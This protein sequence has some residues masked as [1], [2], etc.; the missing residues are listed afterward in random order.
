[1]SKWW[2]VKMDG[3]KKVDTVD[4]EVGS[5]SSDDSQIQKIESVVPDE[6]VET[7]IVN[8]MRVEEEQVIERN[9]KF[10]SDFIEELSIANYEIMS[11]SAKTNILKM[12]NVI[13]RW[14]MSRRTS[15]ESKQTEPKKISDQKSSRVQDL[16]TGESLQTNK[17]QQK[18]DKLKRLCESTD[19]ENNSSSDNEEEFHRLI[20]EG[21][22]HNE[23]KS[24]KDNKDIPKVKRFT[25]RNS[26]TNEN[27]VLE[28]LLSKI[29]S[30]KTPVLAKYDEKGSMSLQ[31]YLESF[32]EYCEDNLKGGKPNLG[33][34]E[35]L[36]EGDTLKAFKSVKDAVDSYET[37]KGKL[38]NWYDDMKE[39]RKERY[40]IEFNGIKPKLS[41]TLSQYSSRTEKI[42]KLAYPKQNIENSSSLKNKFITTLLPKPV[43][44]TFT[45]LVL[46]AGMNGKKVT[47]S[48]I[49]KCARLKDIELEKK[50]RETH[51]EDDHDDEDDKPIEINIQHNKQLKEVNPD[52]SS[53]K[54]NRRNEDSDSS[55]YNNKKLYNMRPPK[56]Y[57]SQSRYKNQ[58][59]YQSTKGEHRNYDKQVAYKNNKFSSPPKSNN[60]SC[61]ICRR[62]GHSSNSCRMNYG[63]CF[64]CGERGHFQR[65]CRE[66][67]RSNSQPRQR[68]GSYGHYRNQSRDNYGRFQHEGNNDRVRG[69]Q[70]GRGYNN[71]RNYPNNDYFNQYQRTHR[72]QSYDRN[73]RHQQDRN[74][75]YTKRD[76]NDQIRGERLGNREGS[77]ERDL[78]R[79]NF[80]KERS[81]DT[82]DKDYNRHKEEV[83]NNRG[84]KNN[85]SN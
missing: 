69:F 37:T 52:D 65:D 35:S 9:C 36:L 24:R 34:L 42:F 80:S 3:Q 26:V 46:R 49:Q 5:P 40:R 15:L 81:K 79:R 74:N 71:D 2:K 56:V 72:N 18:I 82:Q 17:V 4:D 11:I 73:R 8:K 31:S 25:K 54:S 70:H 55:N 29:D 7:E 38:L 84:M 33:E 47:W 27:S 23:R 67:R 22:N 77:R 28:V 51:Q 13:D 41:E 16:V 64:N 76:S 57:Y 30:R 14:R 48:S 39:L 19:T 50:R 75:D 58:D 43:R 85:S 53:G 66:R 83:A 12:T 59:K 44:K 78:G 63:P 60:R 68:D 45:D 6:K 1:M 10:V 62:F 61:S 32:E 20:K 21:N